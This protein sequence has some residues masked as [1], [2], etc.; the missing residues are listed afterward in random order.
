MTPFQDKIT[1]VDILA[2]EEYSLEL[3]KVLED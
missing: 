2:Q 1:T 3:E